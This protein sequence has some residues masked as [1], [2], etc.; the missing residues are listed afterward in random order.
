MNEFIKHKNFFPTH[1]DELD[2]ELS[3]VAVAVQLFHFLECIESLEIHSGD[4]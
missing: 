4:G 1:T 2:A 3:F